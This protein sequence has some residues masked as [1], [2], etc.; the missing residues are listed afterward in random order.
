M[1]EGFGKAVPERLGLA[2]YWADFEKRFWETR[3][4]GFW[5][6]ERQQVFKEPGE[7]SWEAFAAGDWDAS[8]RSIRE[9]EADYAD[10]YRRVADHGFVSHRVRIVEKPFSPYLRWELHLLAMR[11]AK[12]GLTSV[13]HA[14]D[15]AEFEK[16]GPLPEIYTLGTDV[17]Y[18]AV[19]N[20]DG[21][22]EAAN[23]FTDSALISTC[24]R[25]IEDL[26]RAGEPLDTFMAREIAHLDP[27]ATP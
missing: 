13:V 15:V 21:V 1:L 7:P 6:L 14:S 23:R 20:D 11:H 8:L 9:R 22:L 17:M 12:G 26:Y 16:S 25:F 27:P 24:Q 2:E 10:Y 19:Y 3:E 4:P 5:K 18:E